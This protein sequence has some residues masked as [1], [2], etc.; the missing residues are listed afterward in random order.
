MQVL[1][2]SLTYGKP[3][4]NVVLLVC[5]S[6]TYE[7]ER[8]EKVPKESTASHFEEGSQVEGFLIRCYF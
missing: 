3:L 8:E 6:A 4:L 2:S 5:Y 7:V 1:K